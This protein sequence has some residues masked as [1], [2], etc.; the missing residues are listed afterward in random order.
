MTG[1]ASDPI[2]RTTDLDVNAPPWKYNPSAWRH[3]V[4]IC[5]LAGIAALIAGYNHIA[6]GLLFLLFPVVQME[7]DPET[8]GEKAAHILG[9]SGATVA[10]ELANFKT[11]IEARGRPTGRWEGKIPSP[12]ETPHP[13]RSV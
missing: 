2:T 3:R 5:V 9:M 12:D 13:T 8:F 4:P 11:F 7:L 1:S 6:V 10:V